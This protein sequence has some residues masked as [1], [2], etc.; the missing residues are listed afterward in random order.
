MQKLLVLYCLLLPVGFAAAD[1]VFLSDRDG[2]SDIYVMNDHGG[3]IHRITNTPFTQVDL[4]WS[5]DSKQIA[6]STDLHSAN[7][8]KPQQYDIFIMNADGSQ[9]R[10]LTEHPAVDV[11]PSWSPDGKYLAFTSGRDQGLDIYVMEITSR[12]VWQ[13]TNDTHSLTPHWSPNGKYIAYEHIIPQHGRHIY[14]MNAD[15]THE[16]PLLRKQRQLQFGDGAI[17]SHSPRWSPDSEYILYNESEHN[18]KFKRV[19]NRLIVVNKHGRNPT[20]LEIPARWQIDAACWADDGNAVLFAAVPG[21]LDDFSINIFKI[22][23][24][25][26]SDGQITNLTDHPSDNWGMDWTPHRAL[27]VSTAGKS[28]TLWGKIKKGT[29]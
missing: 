18:N 8:G 3:H 17:L 2:K 15:G 13:L 24:Y 25:R 10:N 27:T 28:T 23:K 20:E 16:R 9:Q 29:E 19:D 5:S 26:L 1:I 22:Y 7:P 4:A 6:F 14:I 11:D 12:K 21:G